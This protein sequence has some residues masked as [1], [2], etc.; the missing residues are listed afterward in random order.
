[1]RGG[2]AG[3][4]T[5]EAG[6]YY[7]AAAAAAASE[8]AGCETDAVP[9][10]PRGD[11]GQGRDTAVSAPV[12]LWAGEGGGVPRGEGGLAEDSAAAP[13][14]LWAGSEEAEVLAA[15]APS[16]SEPAGDRSPKST[17]DPMSVSVVAAE[18]SSDDSG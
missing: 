11:S 10:A 8:A 1:V 3:G 6:A 17:S 4:I 13:V 15:G 5:E 2:A 18:N 9:G 16:G 7:P 14:G 12:G